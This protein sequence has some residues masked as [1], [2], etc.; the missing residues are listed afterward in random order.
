MSRAASDLTIVIEESSAL[1]SD[2][3]TGA[4][5]T[6]ELADD[7]HPDFQRIRFT[8][9]QSPATRKFYRLRVLP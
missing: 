6:T 3:W 2:S 8:P 4:N 7:S 9:A 1:S 5:G